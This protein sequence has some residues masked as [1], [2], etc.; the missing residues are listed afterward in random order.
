MCLMWLIGCSVF[1][2][3]DVVFK[4]CYICVFLF[5]VLHQDCT[6]TQDREAHEDQRTPRRWKTLNLTH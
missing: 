6:E 1:N 4:K 3:Y 2:A 5:V